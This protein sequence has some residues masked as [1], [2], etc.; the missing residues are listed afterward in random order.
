MDLHPN[1]RALATCK[2]PFKKFIKATETDKDFTKDVDDDKDTADNSEKGR[3]VKDF[4]EEV[5]NNEEL[6]RRKVKM[7]NVAKIE[8]SPK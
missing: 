5:I 4:Y 8:I 3:E 1:W 2:V 7:E 6:S